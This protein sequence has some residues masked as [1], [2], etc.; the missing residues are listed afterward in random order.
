MT[1]TSSASRGNERSSQ[2]PAW[3]T[4]QLMA[5]RYK[6]LEKN[7]AERAELREQIARHLAGV[8]L[9]CVVEDEPP[10]DASAQKKPKTGR[11]ML[12]AVEPGFTPERGARFQR[13]DSL[14]EKM[15]REVLHNHAKRNDHDYK[16][17][18]AHGGV[19]DFVPQAAEIFGLERK[20]R[21]RNAT[22]IEAHLHGW[23]PSKGDLQNF[24][25]Q[26]VRSFLADMA[27]ARKP[28]IRDTGPR[29]PKDANPEERAQLV[30]LFEERQ[31][32]LRGEAPLLEEQN[33]LPLS[34][35]GQAGEGDEESNE[36][37]DIDDE[38]ALQVREW[39]ESGLKEESP[40]AQALI[41][42]W[43][44]WDE[45]LSGQELAARFGVSPARVSQ[46]KKEI[47]ERL[48]KVFGG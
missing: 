3:M 43:L 24:M 38:R 11:D 32:L 44:G 20:L 27:R 25:R 26:C 10:F 17:A 35:T 48:Q 36:P 13:R 18:D 34:L 5:L 23:D 9:H 1:N 21:A 42:Q 40:L 29:I 45:E 2:G 47:I 46:K 22:F 37:S 30:T 16:L 14:L 7:S 28:K 41:R 15:F 19:S 31:R 4:L 39:L 33:P 6:V 12:S 8:F